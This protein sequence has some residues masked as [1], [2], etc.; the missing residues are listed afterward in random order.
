MDLLY[1][2]LLTQKLCH[3][4]DDLQFYSVLSIIELSRSF[5]TAGNF[6]SSALQH[7]A[8]ISS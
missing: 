2:D 5:Q 7:P 8:V 6:R 3:H 4:F 1:Q